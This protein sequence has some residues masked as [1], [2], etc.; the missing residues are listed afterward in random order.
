MPTRV[1]ASAVAKSQAK[2]GSKKGAKY[3]KGRLFAAVVETV[4]ALLADPRVPDKSLSIRQVRLFIRRRV[5]SFN[6]SESRLRAL[7]KLHAP[8]REEWQ[9]KSAGARRRG[10]PSVIDGDG[11]FVDAAATS[12]QA[13]LLP[14][15]SVIQELKQRNLLHPI[16][17]LV[18]RLAASWKQVK[19]KGWRLGDLLALA[20][21]KRPNQ[22]DMCYAAGMVS[23]LTQ[24][25]R[26]LFE[27]PW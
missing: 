13:A 22:Q 12:G 10:D 18:Q 20:G 24:Q 19:A 25:Q 6:T 9:K 17:D 1:P 2:S 3:L 5:S 8:L 14:C 4:K 16:A 15:W 26:A 23:G 27:V 7:L 21:V 11:C